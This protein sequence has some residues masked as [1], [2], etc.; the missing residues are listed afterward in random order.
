LD[1]KNE[2]DTKIAKDNFT[3]SRLG[4]ATKNTVNDTNSSGHVIAFDIDTSMDRLNEIIEVIY[5]DV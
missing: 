5:R 3:L 4:R 1:H 2:L